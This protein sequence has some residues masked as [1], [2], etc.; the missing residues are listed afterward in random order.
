MKRQGQRAPAR[1]D[2]AFGRFDAVGIGGVVL[3][4]VFLA[5]HLDL[6]YGNY[7]ETIDL[8]SLPVK[9]RKAVVHPHANRSSDWRMV[10]RTTACGV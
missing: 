2:N 9:D 7:H 10:D 5:G 8:D 1:Q 6:K 3:R 4:A